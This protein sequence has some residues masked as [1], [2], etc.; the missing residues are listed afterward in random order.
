MIGGI[1]TPENNHPRKRGYVRPYISCPDKKQEIMAYL[2]KPNIKD[3][4]LSEDDLKLCTPE[5]VHKAFCE[6]AHQHL[7]KLLLLCLAG[8]ILYSVF[9]KRLD[10]EE[11]ALFVVFIGFPS[12]FIVM[13][14]ILA[15]FAVIYE[16]VT[17]KRHRQKLIS[18]GH[19]QTLKRYDAYKN[20]LTEYESHLRKKEKR[21]TYNFDITFYNQDGSVTEGFSY[22]ATKE[23]AISD[24]NYRMHDMGLYRFVIMAGSK[25]IYEGQNHQT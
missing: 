25:F 3:F 17:L 9:I 5:A 12:A 4:G 6:Q 13:G 20:A 15:I 11:V 1:S 18:D 21:N 23:Q 7:G 19:E 2:V 14:I 22:R 10:A 16:E 24:M 8:A